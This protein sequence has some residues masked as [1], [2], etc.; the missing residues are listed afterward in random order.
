MRCPDCSGRGYFSTSIDLGT[1][2]CGAHRGY[3]ASSETC[4]TCDGTG[5]VIYM[6]SRTVPAKWYECFECGGSGTMTQRV[7]TRTYASGIAAEYGDKQVPCK[8]CNGK[9]GEWTKEYTVK[10]YKPDRRTYPVSVSSKSDSQGCLM[11]IS[12]LSAAA[13]AVG[14]MGAM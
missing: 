12:V 8:R 4:K 10:D 7:V 13:V 2:W 6:G 9:R 1:T 5:V 3:Q 11:V 14:C